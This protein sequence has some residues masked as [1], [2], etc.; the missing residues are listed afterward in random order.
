MSIINVR[1]T[2]NKLVIR[3]G[4]EKILFIMHDTFASG[5]NRF[6]WRT[7]TC[8]CRNNGIGNKIKIKI[9]KTWE[10]LR[11]LRENCVNWQNLTRE[12]R[13]LCELKW[14]M[15]GV[16]I[17]WKKVNFFF[18]IFLG[19]KTVIWSL[20]AKWSFDHFPPTV[21]KIWKFWLNRSGSG[22]DSGFDSSL[23]LVWFRFSQKKIKFFYDRTAQTVRTFSEPPLNRE[24]AVRFTILTS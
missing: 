18:W 11:E 24:L 10:N 9:D 4:V 7:F 15:I 3:I 23:V 22:S 20:W 14:E 13:E 1:L 16:F 19:I 17:G 21:K 8:H 6:S 12:L 2:L 5:G